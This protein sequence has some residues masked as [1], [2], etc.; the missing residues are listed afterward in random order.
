MVLKDMVR[1]FYIY[2]FRED[3]VLRDDIVSL[4]T[5]PDGFAHQAESLEANVTL[6]EMKNALFDMGPQKAPGEDGY[7]ALFYQKCWEVVSPTLMSFMQEVWNNHE[8]IKSVNDTLIILVNKMDKLEMVTQFR[9][10]ALGSVV[11][12]LFTK[13]IV[14][15]IKPYL[16]RII[17]PNQSSFIPGR[18]IHH[19]IILL[20]R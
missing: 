2:L 19:N 13:I 10:N 5:Y 6:L 15:C 20:R 12:K 11:Y 4:T 18:N 8:T 9:P 3:Q 1:N 14:N 7:P 16:D 17:S